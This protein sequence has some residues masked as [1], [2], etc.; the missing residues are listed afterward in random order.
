MRAGGKAPPRGIALLPDGE[1]AVPV[2]FGVD[3]KSKEAAVAFAVDHN[4]LAL[5]GGNLG[6]AELLSIWDE[7]PLKH[8]LEAMPGAGELM[9]SLDGEDVDVLLRGPAFDPAQATEQ[10]RLDRKKA[11]QC[12]E[13]GHEFEA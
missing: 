3:S 12:P 4:N 5:L 6:V 13:C 2:I 8:L 9:A 11:V 10:P 1:W 7:E